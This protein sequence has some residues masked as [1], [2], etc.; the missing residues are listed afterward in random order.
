VFIDQKRGHVAALNELKDAHPNRRIDVVRGDCNQI[1]PQALAA[2]NWAG[3]RGVMFLDPY[4]L[5]V[6]W[7]TLEA[8]RATGAIDV[9][10]LVNINGILRQAAKARSAVDSHKEARLTRM[11]GT[12]SWRTDWYSLRPI[13]PDIFGG[14]SEDWDRTA[15][16][17]AVEKWVQQRLRGLFTWVPDP[18]RLY[19]DRGSVHQFSLFFALS[20][21]SGPALGLA[22]RL[23]GHV[24]RTGRSFQVR[25][26]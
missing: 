23:A 22:Q 25:P 7:A 24:L 26:R 10:Y 2:Q 21:A 13:Q 19:M 17:A 14:S 8:I 1:I 20:N 6:D 4:G 15:N 18:L 3:R 9:W 5:N 12:S 11:L 16:E